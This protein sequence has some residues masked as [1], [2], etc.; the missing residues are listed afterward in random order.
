MNDGAIEIAYLILNLNGHH[1]EVDGRVFL[2][3]WRGSKG[4]KLVADWLHIDIL[5]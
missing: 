1:F 4:D 3:A 2:G 5:L